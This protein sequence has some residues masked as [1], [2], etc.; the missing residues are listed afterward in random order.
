MKATDKLTVVLVSIL[1]SAQAAGMP[2][3][4]AEAIYEDICSCWKEMNDDFP[5]ALVAQLRQIVDM[6]NDLIRV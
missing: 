4:R 6:D 5:A 1:E 2:V 3:E